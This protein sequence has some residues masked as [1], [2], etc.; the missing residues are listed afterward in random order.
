MTSFYWECSLEFHHGCQN[1]QRLTG[2]IFSCTLMSLAL[3]ITSFK[4]IVGLNIHFI[5]YNFDFIGQREIHVNISCCDSVSFCLTQIRQVVLLC[6]RVEGHTDKNLPW[7]AC[8]F[9]KLF[10][11]SHSQDKFPFDSPSEYQVNVWKGGHQSWN[12]VWYT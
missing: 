1:V 6:D 5:G 4:S 12:V 8:F 9:K 7:P 3:S 2:E 11:Y 10:P